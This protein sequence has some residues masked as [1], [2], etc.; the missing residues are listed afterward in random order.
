[1]Q[2]K[3]RKTE[4]LKDKYLGRCINTEQNKMLRIHYESKNRKQ[5]KFLCGNEWKMHASKT[6]INTE[7]T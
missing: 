6:M 7:T 4:D 2:K 5:R 3:K 1:M